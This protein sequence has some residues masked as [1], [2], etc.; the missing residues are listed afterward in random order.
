MTVTD[1]I[2]ADTL[3]PGA[4]KA[5]RITRAR[6]EYNSA[7]RLTK[8]YLQWDSEEMYLYNQY[9][10]DNEGRL[11]E[12]ISYHKDG[13]IFDSTLYEYTD[14]NRRK[15]SLSQNVARYE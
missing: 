3:I 2:L 15:T 12:V 14:D 11:S 5:A 4:P 6:K 1:M 10:Y 13:T 8:K 9:A 7:G